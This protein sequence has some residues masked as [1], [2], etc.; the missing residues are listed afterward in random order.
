M[1]FT[2]CVR[3]TFTL[4]D[5]AW[6][7]EFCKL[8]AQRGEC[9]EEWNLTKPALVRQVAE[10]Y[11]QAGSRVILTNTFRA[12]PIS[13]TDH[14]QDCQCAA[15]NR[16]GVKISRQAAGQR[17]LVFASIGPS[18]KMLANNEV[19]PQQLRIAFSAQA[20]ALAEEAP[21][22]LLLETMIDL[23]EA[24]IAAV[25]ALETGL[26]VVV[27]LVFESGEN[28]D[29][30]ITGDTPER[31]SAALASTGV[32]GIGANCC[33]ATSEMVSVCQRLAAACSLPLWIKPNAGLPEL[34]GGAPRYKMTPQEFAAFAQQLKQAGATFIGG[35]CGTT[36]DFI[37]ELARQASN[38]P[39]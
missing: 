2:N 4:T 18:G 11:V 28:K 34:L 14:S 5:G 19:T 12:N 37:R 17:A 13:L 16:A 27:S 35:C 36:P 26:P 20:R 30:T 22:A 3:G 10:S 1:R 31:V 38:H 33:S 24:R 9:L 8:G 7:T 23:E 32:H 6:G 39:A 21:D 15:I 29:R 25:A